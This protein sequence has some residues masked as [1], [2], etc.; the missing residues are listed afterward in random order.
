[1]ETLQVFVFGFVFLWLHLWPMEG[2]KLRVELELQLLAY[3]KARAILELSAS[4]TYAAVYGNT[5]FLTH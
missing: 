4:V 2:P 5:E 3:T 1:M